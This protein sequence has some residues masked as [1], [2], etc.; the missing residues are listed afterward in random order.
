MAV[1][2]DEISTWLDLLETKHSVQ[3]EKNKIFFGF[4]YEDF[5]TAHFVKAD[6]DGE[7]FSWTVKIDLGGDDFLRLNNQE[8]KALAFVYM[9]DLNYGTKF[10][11][12]EYYPKTGSLRIRIEIPLEDAKMTEKQFKRI[13]GYVEN[14][15][16]DGIRG[17][18]KVLE[19]GELPVENDAE[20]SALLSFLDSL[21]PEIIAAIAADIAA[22]KEGASE[23]NDDES[24]GI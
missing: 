23:S 9:L 2:L 8:H 12:W 5:K 21:D 6:E 14:N 7:L 11:T 17:L 10:G 22:K 16:A 18:I 19:T 24:D 4:T 1:T 3:E 15:V 20:D 13:Y